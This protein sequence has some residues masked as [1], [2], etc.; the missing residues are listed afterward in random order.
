VASHGPLLD[1]IARRDEQI[2]SKQDALARQADLIAAL[3]VER[4][5]LA[6]RLADGIQSF[7]DDAH[8]S[9]RVPADRGP[10]VG[11]ASGP[12]LRPAPE[13]LSHA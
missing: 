11:G 9:D 5:G 3:T 2:L 10:V 12:V 1:A 13:G 4:D 7:D 6:I 8:R